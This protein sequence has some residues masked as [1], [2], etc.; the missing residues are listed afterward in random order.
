MANRAISVCGFI[1]YCRRGSQRKARASGQSRVSESSFSVACKSEARNLKSGGFGDSSADAD[2]EKISLA[3]DVP[4]GLKK[5]ESTK[6]SSTGG[7]ESRKSP[8]KREIITDSS[9]EKPCE[10]T[11]QSTGNQKSCRIACKRQKKRGLRPE[12]PSLCLTTE[13]TS[14][15]YR[16]P[17][18]P[19][20]SQLG[21]LRNIQVV[22]YCDA[23]QESR[24]EQCS[25]PRMA[26]FRK[27]HPGYA[28]RSGQKESSN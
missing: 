6:S 18:C 12:T 25:S 4:G 7:T 28:S 21:C 19:M 16:R 11:L 23:C 20:C 15:K 2:C 24:D 8:S 22:C 26:D 3:H 10:T 1:L 14:T 5:S 27:S 9:P 13:N 17:H